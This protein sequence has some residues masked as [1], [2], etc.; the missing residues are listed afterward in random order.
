M[1]YLISQMF[2]PNFLTPLSILL[3]L[4]SLLPISP[5]F[6]FPP[7]PISPL[8]IPEFF[9]PFP[10]FTLYNRFVLTSTFFFFS[11][12]L[13]SLLISL[14]F[15]LLFFSPSISH[16]LYPPSLSHFSNLLKIYKKLFILNQS[17][18][19]VIKSIICTSEVS[20]ASRIKKAQGKREIAV[21]NLKTNFVES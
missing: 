8:P 9:P 16:S 1:L 2:Y 20:E 6:Q 19:H 11:L 21:L 5:L 13:A 14:S 12:S 15:F 3:D 17:F 18:T 10:S 4:A 7:L